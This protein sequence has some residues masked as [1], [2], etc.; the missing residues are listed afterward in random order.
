MRRLIGSGIDFLVQSGFLCLPLLFDPAIER[1]INGTPDPSGSGKMMGSVV[2]IEGKHFVKTL[3]LDSLVA[4]Y[5]KIDKPWYDQTRSIVLQQVGENVD[6]GGKVFGWKLITIIFQVMPYFIKKNRGFERRGFGR[7]EIL[8][9]IA[10]SVDIPPRDHERDN[11]FFDLKPLHQAVK[12]LEEMNSTYEPPKDGMI[13]ASELRNWLGKALEAQVIVKERARL[14]NELRQREELIAKVDEDMDILLH[15]AEKGSLEIKGF[16]FV[17]VGKGDDYIIYR[18][19]GEFILKDYYAR[20]YLFP[21]CRVAVPTFS[22][23]KPVVME[24]YKHPFLYAHAPGQEICMQGFNPPQNFSG[25]NVIHLL[26]EGINALLHGYDG[27]RRNGYHSLDQVRQ[28]IK[29]VEFDDYRI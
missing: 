15:I 10:E 3:S 8:K 2:P 23:F 26:E 19:T 25:E 13:S 18:R 7:G 21:D 12:R 16:G 6:G 17:R 22:P 20:S 11:T 14:R 27:R 5:E 4:N 1:E 28:Y 9:L 29:T 24:K